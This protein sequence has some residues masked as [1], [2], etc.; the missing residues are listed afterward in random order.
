MV[1][2]GYKLT[3]KDSKKLKQFKTTHAYSNYLKSISNSPLY[4]LLL[5]EHVNNIKIEPDIIKLKKE[6]KISLDIA[7][8]EISELFNYTISR[9]SVSLVADAVILKELE[10]LNVDDII[11][12]IEK[13]ADIIYLLGLAEEKY[14]KEAEKMIKIGEVNEN[15]LTFKGLVAY[16][17]RKKILPKNV[18][19]ELPPVSNTSKIKKVNKTNIDIDAKELEL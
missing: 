1:N 15:D 6:G 12:N 8:K 14:Y 13:E 7:E 11:N 19:L 4:S 17:E 2:I 9:L 10:D 16:L 3:E 18:T 5:K